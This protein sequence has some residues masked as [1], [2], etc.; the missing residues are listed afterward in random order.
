MGDALRPPL[1]AAAG[2]IAVET[3][4]L[5]EMAPWIDEIRG[6]P[7]QLADPATPTRIIHAASRGWWIWQ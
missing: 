3:G 4:L 2:P 1:R 6:E 5:D 7:R